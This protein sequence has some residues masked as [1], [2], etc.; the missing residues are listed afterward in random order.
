MTPTFR[1]SSTDSNSRS[2]WAF[3]RSRSTRAAS[4]GRAHALDEWIDV[5]KSASLRGIQSA[6]ALLLAL[7][8]G[9]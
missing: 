1:A 3:R 5:E 8:G 6:L 9:S 2:A 4:G 7:A